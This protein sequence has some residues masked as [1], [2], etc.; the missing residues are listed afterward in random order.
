MSDATLDTLRHHAIWF[1][2]ARDGFADLFASIGEAEVVLIGEA[3]HGTHEFYRARA[4]LTK[5]LIERAGFNIVAVEA[6]WP[7]A[8]RVNRWV[9]NASDDADAD[10]ALGDFLRFPRWMWRNSDVVEFV[11]WL[12]EF[13]GAQAP[14][15]HV[16]FYGLDLYSLHAS[17]DAVLGYL[18][19]VDPD[20]AERARHRYACFED[21]KEDTQAYGYAAT[22]GLSPSCEQAV[23]A[24]L[25]DLRRRAADYASRDGRIAADEFFFA[26]QN[27]RLVRNAE[28]YYRTMFGGHVESWNL[29]DTHMMETLEALIRHVRRHAGSARAVV[30]AHNSHLGDARATEMSMR[31]ELNLGQLVREAY[32]NRAYLVGFTTHAGTVTAAADWDE[33]ARRKRVRPSLEASFERLFHDVG[34][35]RFVLLLRDPDVRNAL[36]TTRLERAIGVIYRPE[37]ERMSHYFRARIV[38]Q[39]DAV[40]HVDETRA[41]EPLERWAIDEADMPETYPFAY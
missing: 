39:F 20:A 17:A 27:A 13:N 36:A 23:V 32:G 2:P 41:L 28:Q 9:R 21:F 8:Y 34:I 11:T 24:Q 10:A 18:K 30:W 1:E 4:E 33:P 14:P 12:R 35:E 22:V 31:G 19:K 40:L 29:R 3:S 7:D 16:G 25:I 26:E 38:D 15:A 37:T 6:D 5:A